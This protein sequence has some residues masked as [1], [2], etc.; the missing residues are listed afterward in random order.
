MFQ[1]ADFIAGSLGFIQYALGQ[2]AVKKRGDIATAGQ[3][4]T[5]LSGFTGFPS[6][7]TVREL[8]N[9]KTIERSQS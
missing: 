5:E 7:S 3:I 8:R 6:L 2:I 1:H 9:M 4:T